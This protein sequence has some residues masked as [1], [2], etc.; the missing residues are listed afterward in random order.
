ML[1]LDIA[2]RRDF[3]PENG[4]ILPAMVSRSTAWEQKKIATAEAAFRRRTR[5]SIFPRKSSTGGFPNDDARNARDADS[6]N[7]TGRGLG[8][9]D[10]RLAAVRRTAD[11]SCDVLAPLGGAGGETGETGETKPVSPRDRV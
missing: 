4:P 10:S 6:Q 2:T 8:D 3:V 1:S 9:R 7:P 11:R 5:A